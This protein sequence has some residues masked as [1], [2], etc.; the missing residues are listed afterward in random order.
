M[1]VKDEAKRLAIIEKTID[2]VYEKG[3]AGIKMASLA[4]QVGISASTL[5]VYYSSKEELIGMIHKELIMKFA[6]QSRKAIN[7]DLPFE[8]KLKSLWMYGI[9]L[10]INNN[11][12]FNFFKQIKQSPYAHLM[13]AETRNI[14]LE[15]AFE[16]FNQGK[17]EGLI[18]EMDNDILIEVMRAMLSH[19]VALIAGK[20]VKLDNDEMDIWYNFFWDAVKR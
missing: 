14:N 19:T 20:K 7:T 6:R 16:L 5:Y 10:M 2:I 17:E 13:T 18:K 4:K 12:E 9:D 1:R 3:I 8:L 11:K 15:L